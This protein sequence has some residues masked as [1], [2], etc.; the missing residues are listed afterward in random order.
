[1]IDVAVLGGGL[2]GLS[3][4]R[5]LLAAGAD[6]VVLEARERVG[7]RVEAVELEDGRVVQGGGEVVGTEHRAYI[8]LVAELGLELEPSYVADPGEMSWGL[9]EGVF[10][11]DALPWMSDAERADAARVEREFSSL[12]ATVDPDDPWAHPDARRLD[13][14]SLGAWLR[15][16]GA[17]PAT[18][19]RHELASLSLACDAPDR[20][21]LLGALRKHATL[22][23]DGFYDLE[24][25]E[26]LRVAEGSAAVALR[27]AAELGDRVRLGQVVVAIELDGG[28]AGIELASGEVVR[29]EA[30]VC[31]LPAGPLR[32]VRV[33]GLSEARLRSLHAQRHALAAKVVVAYGDSFWQRTGQNGLAECDWLFGS[34]WPQ[35]GPVLSLL[36]PPERLAPWLAAPPAAR[37]QSVLSGLAALY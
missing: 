37:R 31:A 14:C 20:T 33:E 15:G 35:Q 34:T 3:A 19:R 16:Q 28:G 23:G 18:L 1:V 29:A 6:V 27:M 11:G 30:V 22:A 2:A 8:D 24:T 21:S 17:L 36:V 12:A 5:D 32:A 10:L 9:A 13:E 26:N 25:W 4:A 7:G